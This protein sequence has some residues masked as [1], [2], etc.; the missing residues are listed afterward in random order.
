MRRPRHWVDVGVALLSERSLGE[1]ADMA[2]R[3]DFAGRT[4]V[5]TGAAGGIGRRTTERLRD[6]GAQVWMWDL[7]PIQVADIPSC[8]VDVRD[9]DQVAAA[10]GEVVEQTG[11]IDILVNCVGLLGGFRPFEHHQSQ[12]FQEIIG[13]NLIGVLEVC[14]Q[15]VLHLRRSAMGR[16][17]NLGSLAGKDGLANMPVYSAASAGVIAFTKALG[18]ELAETPIRVNCVAPG[19]IETGLILDLG[20]EV[21]ER[22]VTVSPMKR[23]GSVDEV[24]ELI[25]WLCSDACT[26][27]TGVVFDIS[28]GRATY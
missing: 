4:P 28:G 19:P 8:A 26:F 23:L 1:G 16:I 7:A 11:G 13:T 20:A 21:V 25:L 2:I 15:V 22:L 27:S 14:A 17:V 12:D 6:A 5:V 24:A 3:Y 9:R 10:L 18:R